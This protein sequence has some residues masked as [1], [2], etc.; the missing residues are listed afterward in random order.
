MNEYALGHYLRLLRD[1]ET[2]AVAL[3]NFFIGSNVYFE[4]DEYSFAPFGFSGLSTSRQGDLDP[5]TLT[6]PNN[7]ISR[8]YLGDALRGMSYSGIP[9]D[10][11]PWAMPYIGE[12]DVCLVDPESRSVVTKLFKYTGQCTSGGWDDTVLN[13][14]LSSLLDAVTSDV[15]TRTLIQRQVGSLPITSNIRLN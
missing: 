2:V 15:P 5:A 4:G 8:G 10:E 11:R 3:Q 7:A 9:I 6:F 14:E 13:L 1:D 12:V